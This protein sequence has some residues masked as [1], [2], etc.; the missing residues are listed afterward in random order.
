MP[1][2]FVADERDSRP[3]AII[4]GAS[5]HRRDPRAAFPLAGIIVWTRRI[6]PD[7]PP[8]PLIIGLAV[9]QANQRRQDFAAHL[10]S[11]RH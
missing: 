9:I 6:W 5:Q 3:V 4:D 8:A 11:A 7:A 10:G 1:G 2:Q